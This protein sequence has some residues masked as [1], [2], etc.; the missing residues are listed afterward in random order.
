MF[1]TYQLKQLVEPIIP[2]KYLR[3]AGMYAMRL[4]GLFYWGKKYTCPCCG[5]SYKKFAS[6]GLVKRQNAL[7]RWCLSLERHRGLWL[8]FHEKTNILQQ[9]LRVLHFAP[10]HQF[11][12]LFKNSP[13][14]TYLSADL[15]MPTAMEKI[16]ITNIP[17]PDNSFDVIICNHVLEHIPDD[18]KAMHELYRVL[19]PNGWA[20]LQTP[21]LDSN[22]TIEDLTITDPKERERLFGQ[23]DHVRI[24][25]NDKKER[26]ESVGFTVILDNYLLQLPEEIVQNYALVREPIWLCKK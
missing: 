8:Y 12:K 11:Q 24:Y 3:V 13:N 18:K 19:A 22:Q 7:C 16:D 23:N 25:G 6:Y 15:D 2:R 4:T 5:H 17:K 21:Q 20:I 9:K 26:L 14:L 1:D 10:E